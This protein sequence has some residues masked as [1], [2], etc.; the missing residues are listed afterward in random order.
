MPRRPRIDL[1]GY[2]HIINRGVN[3]ANIYRDDA[4]YEMFL[5]IACKACRAYRVVLHNYCLMTNHFHL[6]VETE[7][8]NLSLF[9]KHI[10]SN[11]A[12]YFNKKTKRSG[13]L[14]QGRFYSRYISSDA[15]YYTLIQYIEQNPIE[16]GVVTEV[17]EYPYT[18][19]S[20][21][22]NRNKPVACANKS[23]LIEELS[24]ENVQE[25]I[26]VSLDDEALKI[27]KDIEM[28]KVLIVDDT[29][30]ITKSEKLSEHFKDI[31]D[32]IKRNSAIIHAIEDGYTQAE[33]AK[34]ISLSRSALSK[35]VKS[36]YSTPDPKGSG[37]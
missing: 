7:L 18:L 8:E 28:Q 16:A 21:I 34:Y 37:C 24:Y 17:G 12:I 26:G 11:Y 36:A 3:H 22:M 29:K 25:M 4:D 19:G 30:R 15:Y 32:K 20:V 35:I 31:D 9:M 27:L 23:K 6:L 5:K 13:H 33:V 1:A 14:W 10:N 2:H